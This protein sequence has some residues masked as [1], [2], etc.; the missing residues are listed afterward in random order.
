MPLKASPAEQASLLELQELDTRLRQLDHRA[1]TLPQIAELT[2]LAGDTDSLRRE[3]A[4]VNGTLEDAKI[5]LGRIE[6]DVAVVEARIARDTERLQ[7]SSSVKDVAGLE[8]E[9]AGLT[10]R[11]G[12]LEEIELTL[13]ER[14]DAIEGTLRE[15]TA[16]NSELQGR[17]SEIE[18]DRALAAEMV[19]SERTQ[20]ASSRASIASRV[21]A[22][23]TEL[24]QRQRDRYG[25][26][27]SLLQGGTSSAS[28]IKLNEHDMAI[29]RAAA[30]DD[31]LLC[32]ESSAIL[33][34][35]AISG[36]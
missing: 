18:A 27:A 1:K 21:P 29:I 2:A 14:V 25:L 20:V 3:M 9:L 10:R 24:Y 8:S 31:V 32:P 12:E 36:L 17:V 30:P 16:K 26:G 7:A 4:T 11:R 23:L 33:V 22:D 34:R 15:L 19:A 5:E 28:G 6:S 13:M 35:T